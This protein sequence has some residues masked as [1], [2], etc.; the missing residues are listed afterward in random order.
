MQT[1]PMGGRQ[2]SANDTISLV[3]YFSGFGI[4]NALYRGM[5]TTKPRKGNA[6][7]LTKAQKEKIRKNRRI[8]E[9]R[10]KLY[11]FED[12]KEYCRGRI[13]AYSQML[14]GLDNLANEG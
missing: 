7:K 11:A 2:L 6:M 3:I 5:T 9:K 1:F 12:Q 14:H 10:Q 8:W 13:E 4:N